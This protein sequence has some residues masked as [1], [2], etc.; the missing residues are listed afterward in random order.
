MELRCLRAVEEVFGLLQ[1]SA[2]PAGGV[3]HAG[4]GRVRGAEAVGDSVV[5]AGED[6]SETGEL[7]RHAALAEV[8]GETFGVEL[9][10]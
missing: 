1:Q 5:V 10:L 7:G 8:A 4:A 9:V 2:G 6:V 3:P